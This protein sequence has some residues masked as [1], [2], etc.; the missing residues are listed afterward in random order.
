MRSHRF[1]KRIGSSALIVAPHP[2]DETFGCGGTAALMA[3]GG[4]AVNVVF[5]T[6]G[7]A[8]HPGHATATHSEIASLRRAEA[9][10][11]MSILGVDWDKVTFLGARDGSLAGLD[12]GQAA[13]IVDQIATLLSQIAPEAILLPCRRDGSS[14]HDA[15]FALVRR[16][17]DQARL[18]PRIFEFPV[19]SWWNPTLL[20][21]CLLAY[22][23]VWRVELG[24]T[25]DL[26]GI[27]LASYASQTLPIPPQST[28]ALPPGFVSMFLGKEEFFLEK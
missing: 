15:A 25:R 22:R 7:G 13:E 24:S 20:L 21:R 10:S 6:D 27:A 4:V 9:R 3:K 26:K 8:S 23:K 16:A 18:S 28:P 19:W 11:A 14:E 5:L 2:D 1:P 12:A 17:L